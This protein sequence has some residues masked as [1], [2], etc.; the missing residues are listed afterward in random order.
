MLIISLL[1]LVFFSDIVCLQY[2][3]KSCMYV[4]M[5]QTGFLTTISSVWFSILF[6][7][8]FSIDF[9]SLHWHCPSAAAVYTPWGIKKVPVLLLR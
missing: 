3:N 4:C 6:R 7:F 1:P 2:C 5:C 8:S 9:L